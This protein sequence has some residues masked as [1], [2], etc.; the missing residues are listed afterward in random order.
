M[1]FLLKIAY[2]AL[3][4]IITLIDVF[5]L[6]ATLL[7]LVDPTAT[8]KLQ[9]DLFMLAATAVSMGLLYKAY[10]SGHVQENWTMGILWIVAAIVSFIVIYVGGTLVFGK[11]HWQ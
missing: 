10:Q 8:N 9:E 1:T 6:G 7:G 2:Y 4:A 5:Y 3:L 11:P